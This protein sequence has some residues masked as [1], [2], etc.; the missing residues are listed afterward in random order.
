MYLDKV[1]RISNNY[2]IKDPIKNELG[3]AYRFFRY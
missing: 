2:L 1:S 3:S